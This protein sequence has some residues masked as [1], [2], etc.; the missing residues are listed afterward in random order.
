MRV[1]ILH[2][3]YQ[4]SGGEDSCV[5]QESGALGLAGVDVDVMEVSND[6]IH[7]FAA[8]MKTAL[9]TIYSVS[10]RGKV[11]KKISSFQPDVVH[12]H[13]LFPVLTPS[14]YDASTRIPFVQTLHNYRALCSAAVLF[15]EGSVCEECLGKR[16]PWPAVRHACY[17]GSRAGSAAVATTIAVHSL[18]G[19]WRNRVTRFIALTE[20]AR[21]IFLRNLSLREEQIA[22]KPNACAD[23]GIG[24]AGGGYALYVGRLS[25]EKGIETLIRAAEIGL[26]MSLKVVGEGPMS[27]QVEAAAQRGLLEYV[28]KQPHGSISAL[29][30]RARVLLLPS[31]WYEGLPMVIPEA[32]SSGLPVVASDLGALSSLII[33]GHTGFLVKPG[34]AWSLANAVHRL[35]ARPELETTMRAK[36]RARYEALYRPEK[37]VQQLLTIYESSIREKSK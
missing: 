13:N 33:D 24:D 35:A 1:L 20:F 23:L 26:K 37:N 14:V 15:R 3:R 11:A 28:G 34:D 12:V 30:K 18:L 25:S 19:T 10:S 4:I 32:Y 36:S 8:Q 9:T 16:L 21:D 7:G 5:S 17:R 27:P 2:N 22:V 29:M 6:H 31:M